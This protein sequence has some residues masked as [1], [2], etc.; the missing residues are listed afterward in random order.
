[1]CSARQIRPLATE[2]QDLKLDDEGAIRV[3]LQCELANA[4]NQFNQ[5]LRELY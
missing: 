4:F 3:H 1:M 2:L 5:C